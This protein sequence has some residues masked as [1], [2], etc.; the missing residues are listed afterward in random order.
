MCTYEEIDKI[1][2]SWP[3]LHLHLALF[4]SSGTTK[5]SVSRT[6][7]YDMSLFEHLTNDVG[8]FG[9]YLINC[10]LKVKI[11]QVYMYEPQPHTHARTISLDK[12]E[13]IVS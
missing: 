5:R 9:S 13:S 2:I 10:R 6:F 4:T 7:L 1:I 8:I 3:N 12:N 11:N